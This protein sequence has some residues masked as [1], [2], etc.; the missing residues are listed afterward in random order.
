MKYCAVIC[1]EILRKTTKWLFRIVDSLTAIR[2]WYF[3]ETR[4]KRY[5]LSELAR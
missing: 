2:S 5:S 1:H 4:W 3:Q